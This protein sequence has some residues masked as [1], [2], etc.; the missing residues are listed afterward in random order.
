[1]IKQDT[2]HGHVKEKANKK[3]RRL[4]IGIDQNK[5]VNWATK[6]GSWYSDYKSTAEVV[7]PM[8]EAIARD[9]E[10]FRIYEVKPNKDIPP[11]ERIS[12]IRA[13]LTELAQS[14]KS[15]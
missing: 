13:A 15:T 9:L 14:L 11:S 10:K 6:S 4:R 7:S 1:M 5:K 2:G 3:A 12:I 8:A